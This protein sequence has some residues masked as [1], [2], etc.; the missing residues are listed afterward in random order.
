M[1]VLLIFPPAT[2]KFDPATLSPYPPLG[3]LCLASSLRQVKIDVQILDCVVEKLGF[4]LTLE[5]IREINPNIVGISVLTSMRYS[6]FELAKQIKRAMSNMTI[7]VGG[8]HAT[9]LHR[10]VLERVP[11]VDVVVRGEG[12]ITFRDFI[13][14]DD[15]RTVKGISYRDEEGRIIINEDRE[16][17]QDLDSLGFP[18]YDLV[19]MDKYFK[20]AGA[21]RITKRFPSAHILTARGCM[22]KCIFCTTSMFWKKI[23]FHSPEHTVRNIKYL[24]NNYGVKDLMVFDD[25]F[26]ISFRWLERFNH[27]YQQNNFDI[28]Y[29]CFSR[30]SSIT[31]QSISLLKK[32]GCYYILFGIE[33]GSSKILDSLKKYITVDQIKRAVA[34]TKSK[35]ISPGGFFMVGFPNETIDDIAATIDLAKKLKLSE[36]HFA[37]AQLLPGSEMTDNAKL[38]DD[39]WFNLPQTKNLTGFSFSPMYKNELF[40]ERQLQV[41]TQY[42]NYQTLKSSFLIRLIFKIKNQR[43]NKIKSIIY[44]IRD[45]IAEAGKIRY[46]ENKELLKNFHWNVFD[47]TLAIL[48]KGI[49]SNARRL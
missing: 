31:E 3:L 48:Y 28:S 12:E 32:T 10:Q 33:S 30:A 6:A 27:L 19:P 26:P 42:A 34:L 20:F 16:E 1:R 21:Y 11:E 38:N 41:L 22:A 15:K 4:S 44:S 25:T 49:K 5:R 2:E 46:E 29:R 47:N 40:T 35:R 7:V 45:L 9:A 24:V 8:S 37:S 13:L 36:F 43:I 14:A 17:I 18:A 23:R 39:I